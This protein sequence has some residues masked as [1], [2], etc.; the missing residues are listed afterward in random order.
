MSL[1]NIVIIALFVVGIIVFSYF[2]IIDDNGYIDD[3]VEH[4]E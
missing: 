1:R 3:T 2:S 4:D